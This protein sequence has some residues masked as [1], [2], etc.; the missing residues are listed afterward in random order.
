MGSFFLF[1][2]TALF[3]AGLGALLAFFAGT[4][5]RLK[6]H[7][8]TSIYF[9]RRASNGRRMLIVV[10]ILCIA[11]AQ[12]C[13]WFY[14]EANQFVPFED[15]VPQMQISF[16]YQSEH[17]PRVQLVATDRDYQ[18]SMRVLPVLADSFYISTEVVEWKRLFQLLGMHDCYRFTGIYYGPK[19]SLRAIDLRDPDYRLGAGPSGL[20]SLINFMG[21]I[22]P[23]ES[24]V[25]LS[26]ELAAVPNVEY[27]LEL[28][29]NDFYCLRD[30]DQLQAAD[31]SH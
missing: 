3:L 5:A 22:F 18:N 31:N 11:V 6:T 24:R 8:A 21:S 10:G 12:G 26:P 17:L 25:L 2:A 14:N 9:Q 23:A 20:L 16:L 15:S 27:H 4:I 7:R 1:T 19:D 28:A 29:P 13:Y 30:V